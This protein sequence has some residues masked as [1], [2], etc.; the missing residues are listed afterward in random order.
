M[1]RIDLHIHTNVSDGAFSPKEVIDEAVRNNVS[2][3]AISDHDTVDAYN[4]DLF[5]YAKSKNIQLINAVEISTKWEKCGIHVLGYNFDLNDKSFRES[6]YKLRNI[7]HIYLYDVA[8]K[9]NELGYYLNVEE[10]DKIEA[11]TKAHIAL[12]AV[13]CE[14]NKEKLLN[15]FGHIP[16]KGEF[17]ETIMNEGCPAYVKKNTCTPKEAAEIIRKAGGKVVLAHPIAYANEDGLTEDDIQKIVADMKPDGIEAY[18]FY[19]DRNNQRHD[20]SE[21]WCEFAKRNGLFVT[22]SS[23]FHFKDGIRPEIGLV[24]TDL[25]LD[26]DE[27]DEIVRN[28][29][30]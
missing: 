29:V 19:T 21:K 7:R 25:K 17:I 15:D 1:K 23:D 28:I 2:V 16:T 30:E 26:D 11:V 20:E 9:L 12:D 14:K 6:L 5:L 4:E 24:N 8:E 13:N 18:Y 27:I 22:V 3:I 10:L